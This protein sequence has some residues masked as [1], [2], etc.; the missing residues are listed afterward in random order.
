MANQKQVRLK[1]VDEI[2]M[3][4]ELCRLSSLVNVIK[5]ASCVDDTGVNIKNRI[6]N[7]SLHELMS[8]FECSID[9][10]F[11]EF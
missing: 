7:G 8:M 10:M 2:L 4:T 5:Q 1:Q 3:T 6:D 11:A 9:K